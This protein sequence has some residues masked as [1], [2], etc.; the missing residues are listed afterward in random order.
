MLLVV[1]SDKGQ[2][3]MTLREQFEFYRSL[4]DTEAQRTEEKNKRGAWLLGLVLAFGAAEL[5]LAEK[6][7]CAEPEWTFYLAVC[8]LIA[9]TAMLLVALAKLLFASI[10]NSTQYRALLPFPEKIREHHAQTKNH[11]AELRQY[12]EAYATTHAAAFDP[13]EHF[14][15]YLTAQYCE[16]GSFNAA[17]NDRKNRILYSAFVWTLCST[18]P[19]AVAGFVAVWHILALHK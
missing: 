9:G 8:G 11:H 12:D 6:I 4:F 5:T 14:L 16:L 18:V 10:S 17:A 15:E 3:A 13:D 7:K 1:E 2:A 19:I